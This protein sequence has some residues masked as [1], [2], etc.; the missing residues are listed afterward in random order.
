MTVDVTVIVPVYNPGR[1]IEPCIE[2]YLAQTLPAGRREVIFVDDGSTDETPERLDRLAAE[3]PDIRVIHQENSGWPGRPRNV[4]IEHAR[5]EY[6]FF[7]D[8]DDRLGDEALERMVAMARRTGADVVVPKLVGHGRRIPRALFRA[9]IDRAVLGEDPL[10]GSLTPHKLV[11]RAFLNEHHLRFREGPRRLEDHVFVVEAYLVA[12][13]VSVLADYPCYHRLRRGDEGN[14]AFQRWEAKEYFRCVAEVIDVIDAHTEPGELRNALLMRSYTGEMLGK[15]VGQRLLRWHIKAR[16]EIFREV[17]ALAIDRFPANFH[18]RLPVAQRAH[19]QALVADRLDL[20]TEVA[21]STAFTTASAKLQGLEWSEHRWMARIEAELLLP[22]GEPIRLTPQSDGW[23][24]DSRLIPLEVDPGS[25]DGGEIQRGNVDV[26]LRHNV[27]NVE[28]YLPSDLQPAL[29]K[30]AGDARGAHRLVFRGVAELDPA[31]VAGEEPLTRG[32]WSVR[33]RMSA[34]GLSR[35]T[36]LNVGGGARAMFPS[37]MRRPADQLL[38]VPYRS[39]ST[40]NLMFIAIKSA[41]RG[42][43][44][45]ES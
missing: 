6:V 41:H 4:G 21:T 22:S 23:S 30:I 10:F 31:R 13:I 35:V 40:H 33:I 7:C 8:H 9:N 45:G 18:E 17:R 24:V 19:A 39:R 42:R 43:T 5:G 20:M 15:L 12:N 27:E 36:G 3:H 34:F 16:R 28:W 11:R 26:V 2:G 14:A 29:I 1:Y 37:R 38:V 25:L 44:Q 32:R